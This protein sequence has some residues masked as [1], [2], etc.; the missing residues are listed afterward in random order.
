MSQ[1]IPPRKPPAMLFRTL[2]IISTV[3]W[4]ELS[5]VAPALAEPQGVDDALIIIDTHIDVPYR[6]REQWADV[7]RATDNGDFD[8][9]RAHAGGLDVAF[10]SIYTP[11]DYSGPGGHKAL[12]NQLI[13]SVEAMVGRAPDRFAMVTDPDAVED[14]QR[15]G[16]IGLALGMENGSPIETLADLAFFHQRGVRYITLAHALSN[17][18]SDSSYDTERP[19][20]G[21]SAFGA[22]VVGEM[23]R[24]G[25]MVDVSH[26]SDAAI[27]GVLE[28]SAA[29]VIASHSSARHFTPGFERNL[30]DDLIRAIAAGGGVVQINFGSSFLTAEAND[31]YTRFDAARDRFMEQ[32][33][34]DRN[35]AAVA[36]WSERY[37]QDHPLPFADLAD[38]LDH[39]DHVRD[40][41]GS[42]HI[43]I[44]SD[45][46]G[47]GDSLPVGLKDV[48]TYPNLIR[49]LQSR[50]YPP[51]AVAQIAG[52]NLLR[53]WRQVEAVATAQTGAGTEASA[54]ISGDSGTDSSD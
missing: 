43:G 21:L 6:L 48:S 35:S 15:Q 29:P 13:D 53:V 27:H 47:V 3:C 52:G 30:S 24:L 10:M 28:T 50:G 42:A 39:F 11:S 14:L 17:T 7:T 20:G 19:H 45:Y 4:G 41:V 33:Q 51:A 12:A 1:A 31:W 23:N 25:M 44:G 18:L 26:L 37:R 34:V 49:G 40:L 36:Q 2:L 5:A 22:R 38:V 16:R 46:D 32:Q 9:P 8:F 54:E